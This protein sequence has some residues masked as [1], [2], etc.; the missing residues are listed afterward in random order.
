MFEN[1]KQIQKA[2][3]NSQQ[4]QIG[5]VVIQ[6]ISE[7]RAREICR[8]TFEVAKRDFTQE[9]YAIA[10]KRV[11]RFEDRF[12]PKIYEMKAVEMFAD[13]SFQFV[14]A[15]AQRTAAATER[16]ADY[17]ML[18]ELLLHRIE[19]GQDRKKSVGIKKA[20]EIVDQVSDDALLGLTVAYACMKFEAI[21][22]TAS[23]GLQ[24]LDNLFGKLIYDT[25]PKGNSWVEHLELL[26]AIKM[27]PLQKF[28]PLEDR[29]IIGMP[30]CVCA[31]IKVDS[32][33]YKEAIQILKAASLPENI[34][35][36]NELLDGYV[37]IPI[38]K[39]QT[40]EE[41]KIPLN[42]KVGEKNM[43]LNM[44]INEEQKKALAKIWNLY[45]KDKIEIVKKAFRETIKKYDNLKVVVEWWNGFSFAFSVTAVGEVLAHSN[46]KRCDNG[47]PA[48]E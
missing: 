29:Y 42:I 44:P 3:D 27:L 14:L 26:D 48:F 2:G 24:I 36:E 21:A 15:A 22:G 18:S 33:K 40:I 46:A 8:E 31:G 43:V 30:G 34:L 12:L 16:E 1:D 23:A 35:V 17:D 4:V 9:A 13:P 47:I 41:M 32:D 28:N 45:E 5:Q 20:I 10:N 38:S 11:E 25:L 6:G 37:R 39:F 7:E 19:N